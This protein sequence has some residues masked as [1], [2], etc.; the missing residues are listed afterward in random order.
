[1]GELLKL[2]SHGNSISVLRLKRH[3]IFRKFANSK[4]SVSLLQREYDGIKWYSTNQTLASKLPSKLSLQ[5]NGHLL[6]IPEING[7]QVSYEASLSYTKPF[8]LKAI[9][10]YTL[11]WPRE[12]KAPVHGDLTMDNILF[13]DKEVNFFDWEHFSFKGEIWG[14]DIVYLA[15]SAILLNNLKKNV[16]ENKEIHIIEIW[17]KLQ[18]VG[19]NSSFLAQPLKTIIEIYTTNR[20]WNNIITKS[21]KKLFPMILTTEQKDY[22]DAYFS[23]LTSKLEK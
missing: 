19:V 10:H 23:N 20:E 13:N 15:L 5:L 21:P 9:E 18:K 12:E 22:F 14:F 2:T 16:I 3:G 11:V 8:V 6:D 4:E 1:M 17:K 7:N